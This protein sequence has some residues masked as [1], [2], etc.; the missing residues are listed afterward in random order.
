MPIAR[1]TGKG[2][3]AIAVSVAL[4][5]GC[6]IAERVTRQ[7]ADA[8]RLQVMQELRQLQRRSSPVPIPVSVPARWQ[9][10]RLTVG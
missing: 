3:S 2:L 10:A 5:W 9:H 1:I 4:L 7:Q 8:T 6:L